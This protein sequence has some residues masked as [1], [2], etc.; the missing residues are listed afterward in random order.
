VRYVLAVVRSVFS[1]EKKLSIA[2]LPQT[3]EALPAAG[4]AVVG[5]EPMVV[6]RLPRSE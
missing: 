3:L 6:Y 5:Q 2:A 1:E 4:D